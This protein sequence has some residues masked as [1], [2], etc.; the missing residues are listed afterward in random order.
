MVIRFDTGGGDSL[1]GETR[2]GEGLFPMVCAFM[3]IYIMS[4]YA[5]LTD[6][7]STGGD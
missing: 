5:Y 2:R 3:C 6:C 4:M 7:F 1:E